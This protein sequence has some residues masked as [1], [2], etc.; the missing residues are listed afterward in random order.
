MNTETQA[1]ESAT[2]AKASTYTVF[3]L[4]QRGDLPRRH[5]VIVRMYKDGSEPETVTYSLF[6]GSD[7]GCAMPMEHALKFL[8]DPAFKVVGPTGNRI[9]PIEKIDLSKPLKALAADEVVVKYQYL[10]RDYL[11]KLVK[12]LPGSEDVKQNAT[13][14]ELAAHMIE[15]RKSLVGMT[16]GEKH[17]A[18]MMAQGELG[19]GM[20]AKQL[21]SMFPGSDRK[22][23]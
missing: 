14:D 22:V 12:M 3:D 7:K 4:N 20:D 17:L 13:S 23:A 2:K 6:S 19:G 21:E 15:W 10:A 16:D 11:F 9:M 8:C 18:E 1:A 5:D